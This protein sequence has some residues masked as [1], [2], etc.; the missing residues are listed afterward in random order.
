MSEFAVFEAA[1]DNDDVTLEN[2]TRYYGSGSTVSLPFRQQS[3]PKI[4]TVIE[5]KKDK[6][7][8][9]KNDAFSKNERLRALRSTYSQPI[10]YCK[11]NE[12]NTLKIKSVEQTTTHDYILNSKLL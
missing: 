2:I 1:E 4:H 6:I 8:K 9:L 7:L 10:T 3:L 5:K 11:L 12:K